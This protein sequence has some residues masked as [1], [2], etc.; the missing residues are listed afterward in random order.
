MTTAAATADA[1]RRPSA[2]TAL[3]VLCQLTAA[4]TVAV[5]LLN[6][7]YAPEQ[8]FGLAVRTSWALLRSLGFLILVWHIR[9]GRAGARPLG[10]ILTVTTVFAVGRLVVPRTGTP[11]LPGIL[12][13]ATFTALCLAVLWL[14]YR[15]PSVAAFLV[16]HQPRLVIDKAGLGWRED[17]PRRAPVT[18]WLLTSRVAAFT[19][20]PLMLV[21]CL[22]AVGSVADGGIGTV[23]LIALWFATG[24]AASWAVAFTVVFL[25]RGRGWA[26]RL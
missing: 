6:F 22:V 12:G 24:I 17:A 7:W 4:A 19:Y 15:S 2:V 10:L 26:R 8:G 5:E 18:G 16:R 13:F 3:I 25:M 14:L 23:P 11:P 1:V 9:R 20:T 21:P